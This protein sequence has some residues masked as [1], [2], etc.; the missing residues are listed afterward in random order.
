M[1]RWKQGYYKPKNPEKCLN[2][3]IIVFRSSWERRCMDFFDSHPDV[4]KW[5]S[6]VL[7]IPY[8]NPLDGRMHLYI[9]DF[10]V[11]YIDRIGKTHIEV[12]EIKPAKEA[13]LK[14]AKSKRDRLALAVNVRKWQYATAWCRKNGI[15]FRVLKEKDLFRGKK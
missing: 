8:M 5:G 4:L 13:L 2:T 6:E 15:D 12:I 3:D 1:G 9:P 7:K 11:E 10:I 14:K